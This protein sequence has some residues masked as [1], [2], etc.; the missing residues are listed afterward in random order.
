M[1]DKAD[2]TV[3]KNRSD[4]FEVIIL[5]NGACAG[6]TAVNLADHRIPVG[7][8]TDDKSVPALQESTDI[9][10]LKGCELVDCR[11]FAKAF[12]VVFK[13]NGSFLH[14]KT[15]ALVVAED[16]VHHPN[17]SP[18]GL[19]PTP[20]TID[21]SALEEKLIAQP[22][23]ALFENESKVAFFCGWHTDTDPSVSLRMLECC[24]KLQRLSRIKTFFFTGNLKVAADGAESLCRQAKESGAVLLK[25]TRTYPTVQPL[26]DDCFEIVYQDES[27]RS[28]FQL[29]ADWIVVDESIGPGP[30][31]DN[32][33]ETLGI[34]TDSLGFLQGDN[35]HRLSNATNR[36]G[37]FV[38][39]GSRGILSKEQQ[40]ADADQVTLKLLEYRNDLDREPLPKVEI[41]SQRCA[42]CLTCYRLCPHMAIDIGIGSGQQITVMPQACQSCGICRAGCPARA[43]DI[44]DLQLRWQIDGTRKDSPSDIDGPISAAQIIVL[45][46]GRSAGQ[47]FQ[48]AQSAGRTMPQGVRFVEVPCGGTVSHR[49]LLSAFETGADGVMVCTCHTDNCKSICG[50]VLAGKRAASALSTLELAGMEKERLTVTSVAAHMG[51][52]FHS[53]VAAFVSRIETLIQNDNKK[54]SGT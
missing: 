54:N 39:G 4:V 29:N 16:H 49:H 9:S 18:Y 28:L 42:R 43:I 2:S 27:T 53:M 23:E 1:N 6:K 14:Y 34:E 33:A 30:L 15:Q 13:K 17:Y 44:E 5:G 20:R 11:G 21:I 26:A 50:N 19:K 32:L 41:S 51:G 45:G 46:C 10:W 37:V 22:P 38:A 47:A 8:A 40:L 35:V 48:L 31:L 24:L 25:F 3:G 12:E 7:L 36:R 52:E